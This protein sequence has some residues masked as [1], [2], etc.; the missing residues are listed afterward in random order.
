MVVLEEVLVLLLV[1][2]VVPQESVMVWVEIEVVV[3]V[4]SLVGG[5]CG[6]TAIQPLQ[7]GELI[8][9]V[10]RITKTAKI[11]RNQFILYIPFSCKQAE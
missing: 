11:S 10:V 2:V 9:N 8:N 5:S 1:V 6:T 4:W 7:K 3:D